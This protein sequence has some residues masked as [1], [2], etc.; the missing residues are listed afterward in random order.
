MR[1]VPPPS[2]PLAAVTPTVIE[3]YLDSM[4]RQRHL[5]VLR[6]GTEV[7]KGLSASTLHKHYRVLK[8]LLRWAEDAGLVT[9]S[10]LRVRM[11]TPRTLPR[12]PDD[13]AIELLFQHAGTGV[14]GA[15]NRLLI[16]LF[17]DCGLRLTELLRVR[18][19]DIDYGTRTVRITGLQYAR[20]TKTDVLRKYQRSSPLDRLTRH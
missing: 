6:D 5:I 10:P 11:K 17:L 2:A 13:H 4:R 18:L 19:S 15:R 7:E 14:H 3:Q 9:R 16:S 8:A 20:L 1:I 12:A